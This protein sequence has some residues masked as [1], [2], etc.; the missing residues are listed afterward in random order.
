MRACCSALE[1]ARTERPEFPR[2]VNPATSGCSFFLRFHRFLRTP[3]GPGI[4]A[5]GSLYS[6]VLACS[7]LHIRDDQYSPDRRTHAPADTDVPADRRRR[8]TRSAQVCV[9]REIHLRIGRCPTGRIPGLW[10]AIKSTIPTRE[11]VA[12]WIER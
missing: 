6:S 11:S 7:S 2:S 4:A 3:S 5:R 12:N 8:Y 9:V 10:P 1:T